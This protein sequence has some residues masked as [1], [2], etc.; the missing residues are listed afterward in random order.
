[1]LT[2]YKQLSIAAILTILSPIVSQ[3]EPIEVS[4]RELIIRYER[5]SSILEP[6]GKDLENEWADVSVKILTRIGL[7]QEKVTSI[8]PVHRRVI[9]YA[10]R[11]NLQENAAI[12]AMISELKAPSTRLAQSALLN[13]LKGKA[14]A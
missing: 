7:A 12:L 6:T 9:D 5:P 8:L 11:R 3:A 13:K 4:P 2:P 14:A 1:M 10:R